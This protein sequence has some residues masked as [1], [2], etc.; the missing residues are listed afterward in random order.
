MESS[1][2]LERECQRNI[3]LIWL[4][5]LLLPGFKTVAVADTLWL[6]QALPPR[7]KNLADHA[8]FLRSVT[9][10]RFSSHLQKLARS[11]GQGHLHR[12]LKHKPA[13]IFDGRFTAAL[14]PLPSPIPP[15][16]AVVLSES[17][18]PS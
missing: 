10:R 17:R 5:S 1:R 7:R 14:D 11:I 13:V 6:P 18:L 12:R 3:E 9:L 15:R 4:I 16:D 8:E 2:R